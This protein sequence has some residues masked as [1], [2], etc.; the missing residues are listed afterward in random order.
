MLSWENNCIIYISGIL[1]HKLLLEVCRLV[2]GDLDTWLEMD[3]YEGEVEPEGACVALEPDVGD[4][5][6]AFGKL[7]SY[8]G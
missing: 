2:L 4:G 8:L 1:A 3:K 5:T 7:H 6:V